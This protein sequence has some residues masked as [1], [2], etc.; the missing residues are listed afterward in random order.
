MATNNANFSQLP[1]TQERDRQPD[2]FIPAWARPETPKP[3]DHTLDLSGDIK[4]DSARRAIENR[5]T[6]TEQLSDLR[7]SIS[8]TE[9][10]KA[11][12]EQLNAEL[13]QTKLD[14][15]IAETE[16]VANLEPVV[17]VQERSRLKKILGL[18]IKK[19]QVVSEF[20]M[21]NHRRNQLSG[22][23][24]AITGDQNKLMELNGNSAAF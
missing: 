20:D 19:P 9:G 7:T 21:V 16:S 5:R 13:A 12:I 24:G 22:V 15:G 3:Q 2:A 14:S 8:N 17:H 6:E 1:T 18:L 23:I 10:L 4:L 11:E